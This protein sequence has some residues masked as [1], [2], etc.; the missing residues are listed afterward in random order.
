MSTKDFH[1]LSECF[2]AGGDLMKLLSD[3]SVKPNISTCS[4][5]LDKINKS[6]HDD[7]YKKKY[8]TN[9]ID[10]ANI[11]QLMKDRGFYNIVIQSFTIFKDIDAQLK[12]INEMKTAGCKTKISTYIPL[13]ETCYELLVSTN[14]MKY[15][16]NMFK[17]LDMIQENNF[18]I[19]DEV[20][21]MFYNAIKHLKIN[22]NYD[23]K[24]DLIKIIVIMSVHID[25][26][27]KDTYNAL[28]SCIDTFGVKSKQIVEV[29]NDTYN[30][31]G[32]VRR[33]IPI[34]I[35]KSL[36]TQWLESFNVPRDSKLL[37]IHNILK[38]AEANIFKL[39]N[40]VF[41]DPNKPIAL[42]DGAN[43][44]MYVNRG[45]NETKTS[46]F[47]QINAVVKY[48]HE[49]NWNVVV[50]IYHEHLKNPENNEIADIIN[51][52]KNPYKNIVRYD[53]NGCN[54][55]YLWI[56]AAFY[57]NNIRDANDAYIVTNDIMRNHHFG[58]LTSEHFFMFRQLHQITYDIKY[59]F[60]EENGFDDSNFELTINHVP[61]YSHFTHVFNTESSHK[62]FIPFT[63][64]NLAKRNERIDKEV[65]ATEK[66]RDESHMSKWQIVEF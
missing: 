3:G 55:D 19:F 11:Y 25:V 42:I 6:E 53:V 27:A 30:V 28:M 44:G 43:I 31:Y 34:D 65:R 56:L 18:K 32:L 22:N 66:F 13:V 10:Y 57:Y 59:I 5:L 41:F 15:Y 38:K 8:I 54:D 14:N 33:K 60:N 58:K 50:F 7:E 12:I 9:V 48:F 29:N 52:W 16:D 17:I 39:H 35:Y 21:I 24:C 61:L 26:I 36:K 51:F 47:R 45:R 63:Q 64:Q 46:F 40:K 37:K 4:R 62:L 20:F 23:G 2:D 1:K 49:N